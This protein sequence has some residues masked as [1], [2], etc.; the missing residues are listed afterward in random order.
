[1]AFPILHRPKNALAKQSTHFRFIG[2][3]VD[4]LR[5]RY[6]TV[7]ALEN[8]FR[9]CKTDGDPGEVGVDLFIFSERHIQVFSLKFEIKK[10]SPS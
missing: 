4:R 2:P 7:R 9:R 5:L 8:R 6:L 1:M 10:F 3:V